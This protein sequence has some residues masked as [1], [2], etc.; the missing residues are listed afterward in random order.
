MDENGC[1]R[2]KN[3]MLRYGDDN[4]FVIA[5]FQSVLNV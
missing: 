4:I 1:E 3:N 2:Q 5:K